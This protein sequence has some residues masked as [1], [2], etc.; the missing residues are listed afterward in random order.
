V[1]WIYLIIFILAVF[2]PDLIKHGIFF[3]S[4]EKTEE[5][6][7]LLLGTMAFLIFFLKEKKLDLYNKERIE[8][9]KE[10][11]RILKDLRDSYSYIGEVNRK[12]DILQNISEEIPGS[13]ALT[14][15]EEKVAYNSII[16]AI[17]ILEKTN[18]FAIRFVNF[19]ADRTEKEIKGSRNFYTNME[20]KFLD[21]KMNG[22]V[23]E[24]GNFMAVCTPKSIG[25]INACIIFL[26]EKNRILEDPGMLKLLATQAL[27]LFTCQRAESKMSA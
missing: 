25:N 7:I 14:A 19:S 6:A 5:L 10:L 21:K 16:Q 1:Y 15:E 13:R 18:K 3:I 20:N 24:N 23:A 9:Q 2:I 22:N 12:L 11:N 27:F 17:K 4:E 26:K 8:I